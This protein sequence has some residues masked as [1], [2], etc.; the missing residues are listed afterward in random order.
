MCRRRLVI[1]FDSANNQLII[2]GIPLMIPVKRKTVDCCRDASCVTIFTVHVNIFINCKIPVNN[3]LH[4][5]TL[6]MYHNYTAQV[7]TFVSEC[8]IFCASLR[9]S[10]LNDRYGWND[11]AC[12]MDGSNCKARL[13]LR[14]FHNNYTHPNFSPNMLCIFL[15]RYISWV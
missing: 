11:S 9:I 12:L 14:Y 13:L 15:I 3:V 8:V 2:P 5:F 6:I 4:T 10:H 7:S 1:Q